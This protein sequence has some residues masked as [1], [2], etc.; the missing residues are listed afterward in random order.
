LDADGI[1][2]ILLNSLADKPTSGGDRVGNEIQ[3]V[4]CV[5]RGDEGMQVWSCTSAI[6]A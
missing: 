6:A 2:A 4:R 1:D 3:P 5:R